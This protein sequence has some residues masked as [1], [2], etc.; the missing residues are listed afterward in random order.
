MATNKRMFSNDIVGSDSFIEMPQTSQNLYFHLGM[1]CDDDGFVNPN[2]TMRMTGSNKNDLD[3]LI[4]KKFLLQF[5]NG[6]VV[7]KHHRIN[8]NWD[9]RDCRR[10]LY[11]EQLRQLFIKENNSYTLDEK[12]GEPVELKYLASKKKDA[13]KSPYDGN[14][15]E[16]R[17]KPVDRIEENRIDKNRTEEIEQVAI[18]PTKNTKFQKPTL[19]ELQSYC[20][21]RNN[22]VRPEKFLAYYESNGWRVGK[23]PMKDWKAC[24]RTWENSDFTRNNK[25]VNVLNTGNESKYVA[26]IKGKSAK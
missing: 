8:N 24:V 2:I 25:P 5:Q 13:L 4:G 21:E 20:S 19:T 26:H 16:T 22:S 11:T 7:I 10:T 1:R 9:S 17:R 15:T 14:P 23:N 12:K 18:A 6:V 3:I